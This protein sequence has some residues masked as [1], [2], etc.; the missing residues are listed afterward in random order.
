M[1]ARI[2]IL[3]ANIGRDAEGRN[4]GGDNYVVEFPIA[5][6]EKRKGEERTSWYRCKVWG[7]YGKALESS[8]VKGAR[9][10]VEGRVSVDEWTDRDGN[11]RTTVEVSC[12]TVHVEG[13]EMHQNSQHDQQK[14]NGYQDDDLPF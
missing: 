5:S 8:L 6:N 1:S 4:I 12:D 14:Q 3:A 10:S 7:N 2:T 11:K 9:I 13:R